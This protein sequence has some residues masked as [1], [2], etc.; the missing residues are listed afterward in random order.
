[1][2]RIIQA[3]ERGRQAAE[4]CKTANPASALAMIE[5]GMQTYWLDGF[6]TAQAYAKLEGPR[7]HDS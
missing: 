5:P 4:T 1:M 7:A 6:Y 3:F 2:E